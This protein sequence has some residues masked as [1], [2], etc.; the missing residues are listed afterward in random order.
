MTITNQDIRRLVGR[1]AL[2][3][4]GEKLGKITDVYLDEQT[5]KPE[6]LAVNTGLLG[7]RISFVPVEAASAEGD[8][9]R[10]PYSKHQIEAAPNAEADGQLSMEEEARLYAHYG[11]AYSDAPS[12]SGLPTARAREGGTDGA[13]T[14]SEEELRVGKTTRE[15]GRV[16][17]RKWV[18]TELVSTTVPV[19]REEVR[20]V[21][22]PITEANVD[23]AMSG[24]ELSESIHEAV[25]YEEQVVAEKRVV[26]MERV[27]LEKEIHTEEVT[28]EEDLRKERI[29]AEGDILG[30][31][32]RA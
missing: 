3:P 4:R 7:T 11:L 1:T 15:A 27:R 20:I 25:L 10:L 32:D 22:E 21:R 12:A 30:H 13:L 6:W 28:V 24:P 5:N 26:P 2:G 17:L 16:R 9:V 23:R 8:E 29:A 14:R 18:E 19:N 31:D